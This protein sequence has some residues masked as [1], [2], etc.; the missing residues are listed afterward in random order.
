M[1]IYIYIHRI[2]C[3]GGCKTAGYKMGIEPQKLVGG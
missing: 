1:D 3:H 2:T